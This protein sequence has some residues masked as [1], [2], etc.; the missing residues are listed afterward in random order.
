MEDNIYKHLGG[1][2]ISPVIKEL[3]PDQSYELQKYQPFFLGNQKDPK[4]SLIKYLV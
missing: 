3:Q 1:R 2:T 4:L